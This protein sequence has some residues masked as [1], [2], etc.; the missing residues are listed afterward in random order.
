MNLDFTPLEKAIRQFEKSLEF[1]TS[2][3][4]D[5]DPG[6][7]EQLRYSV[8]HCFEIAYDLSHRMLKRY[9][10]ETAANADESDLDTFKKVITA[11][12]AKGLL[13]SEWLKWREY[14]QA[15]TDSSHTY[16]ENKAEAVYAIAPDFLEAAKF[17]YGQLVERTK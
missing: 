7:F 17:L 8:I 4:A 11:G 13:R 15:R 9:L 1:A 5:T 16:N 3:L 10:E 14:R 12:N 6:V 2:P